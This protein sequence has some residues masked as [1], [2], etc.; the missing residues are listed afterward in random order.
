MVWSIQLPTFGILD[1]LS[2]LSVEGRVGGMS[3]TK[4]RTTHTKEKK[5][6]RSV[7]HLCMTE[8]TSKAT[9]AAWRMSST[10]AKAGGP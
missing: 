5:R 6:K 1:P 7:M 8:D 2:F 10:T 3:M 4:P 9:L